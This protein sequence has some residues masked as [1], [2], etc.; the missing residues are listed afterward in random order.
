MIMCLRLGN[1]LRIEAVIL[2][3]F[4]DSRMDIDGCS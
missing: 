2:E 4:S 1:Y 3:V